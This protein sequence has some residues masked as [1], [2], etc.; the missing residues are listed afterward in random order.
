MTALGAAYLGGTRLG[1]LAGCGLVTELRPGATRQLSAAL[2]WDPAP[3]CP[4]VF[5][6]ALAAERAGAGSAG[7]CA[8]LPDPRWWCLPA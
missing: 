1:A 4:M 6:V 5:S 8:A 2:T 7:G 3:W